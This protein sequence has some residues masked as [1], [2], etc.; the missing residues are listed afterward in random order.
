MSSKKYY[1]KDEERIN[2]NRQKALEF[3]GGKCVNC[4]STEKLEFDHIND[5]RVGVDQCVSRLFSYSWERILVELKRCQ[6]LCKPCHNKKTIKD[7]GW[8]G[9]VHGILSTYTNKKCRCDRCRE[10]NALYMRNR[11]VGVE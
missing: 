1:P 8:G 10:S 4:G 9:M 3:L 2:A 5:D 7:K 11:L 6:L